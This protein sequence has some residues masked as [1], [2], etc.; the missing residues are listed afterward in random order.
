MSQ[1]ALPFL[2]IPDDAIT[3]DDWLIGNPGE[4]ASLAGDSLS[5]WDYRQDVEISA[6][7]SVDFDRVAEALHI[8]PDKLE[9]RLVLAAG[10]GKGRLPRRTE[11]IATAQISR[12]NTRVTVNRMLEGRLLSGRLRLEI[13]CLLDSPLSG[14]SPLSPAF[15]GARLWNSVKEIL[16]E[17]KESRFPVEILSFTEN[18]SGYPEQHAPWVLRW[19]P[20]MLD[21]EFCGNVRLYVNADFEDIAQ[22]FAAAEKS[23]VH[24]IMGNV[25]TQMIISALSKDSFEEISDCCE[26]G[27]VGRQI[28]HWIQT[29]FPGQPLG[30]VRSLLASQPGRFYGAI[31]A[32]ADPGDPA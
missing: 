9:L 15:R 4:P 27:S 24:M 2:V 25:I 6:T 1:F 12:T 32:V 14:G 26:A 22:R 10:T 3:I 19:R 23:T 31:L 8:D 28:R 29:A 17:A 11:S 21:A 5:S 13:S 30:S 18:Y 16:L 20:E 7:I